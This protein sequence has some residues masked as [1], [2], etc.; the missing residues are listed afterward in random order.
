[1]VPFWVFWALLP[2]ILFAL[3]EI[4]TSGILPIR[5]TQ[6]LKNPAKFLILVQIECTQSLQFWFILG[7]NLLP[8]N[9]KY[10]LKQKFMEK[11]DR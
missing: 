10:C 2:Q 5:Q 9:Q 7:P 11:L 6:C 8:E 3:A 1:M 4:L